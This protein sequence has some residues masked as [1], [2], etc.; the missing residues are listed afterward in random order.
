MRPDA[1]RCI[2]NAR[3]SQQ[4]SDVV[5]GQQLPEVIRSGQQWSVA[6]GTWAA[7]LLTISV[8]FLERSDH[9][10][11]F[12]LLRQLLANC[13][14]TPDHDWKEDIVLYRNLSTFERS[15]SPPQ[16]QPYKQVNKIGKEDA[17]FNSTHAQCCGT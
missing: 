17:A 11:P 1:A 4:L 7:A 10:W 2:K 14:R 15:A 16:Q 8:G 13:L 3:S 5:S 9:G 12:N 6:S